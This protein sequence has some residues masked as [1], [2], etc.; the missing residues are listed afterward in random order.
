MPIPAVKT[1]NSTPSSSMAPSFNLPFPFEREKSSTAMALS[2]ATYYPNWRKD[3]NERRILSKRKSAVSH[4]ARARPDCACCCSA[5]RPAPLE[6]HARRRH[7]P[8][9]RRAALRRLRARRTRHPCAARAS[10][11]QGKVSA[12]EPSLRTR[13]KTESAAQKG[14]CLLWIQ[15]GWAANL[16]K[17]RDT[18]R[19]ASVPSRHR[20]RF[21]RRT[22]RPH[23]RT[24]RFGLGGGWT[25]LRSD[26]ARSARKG[27][28]P[29]PLDATARSRIH[30][31]A[32]SAH[33]QS[34]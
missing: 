24:R 31:R 30:A 4:L 20:A 33:G 5:R 1:A 23:G 21:W 3:Q 27:N 11:S 12:D 25:G 32:Q 6:L 13:H 17:R 8:L 14:V 2:F 29:H 7:G 10:D 34:R 28:R 26:S 18:A 19:R 16:R 15:F 9:L 22:S